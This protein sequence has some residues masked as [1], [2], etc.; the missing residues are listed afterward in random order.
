M[1]QALVILTSCVLSIL[2]SFGIVW[3]ERRKAQIYYK[4]MLQSSGQAVIE[5][6]QESITGQLDPILEVNKRAMG[7]IGSIGAQTKKVQ[8]VE[9]QVMQ[10][11]QDD[12]PI[13]PDMIRSFSPSL[14]DTLEE[15]PELLPKALQAYQK[16]TGGDLGG[17]GRRR[18]HPFGNREE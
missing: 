18:P 17:D 16:I 6:I 9:R 4:D 8:M 12:L 15:Y 13:S 3:Y 14:A 11:V 10:A 1:D 5:T 2:A 7:I